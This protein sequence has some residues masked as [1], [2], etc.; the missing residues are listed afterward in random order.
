MID[1]REFV[2]GSLA[3][4]AAACTKTTAPEPVPVAK[5][6]PPVKQTILILGGTSFIGPHIVEAAL[7]RG[8]TITLFNRG[9]TRPGLFPNVEKL[10]GDR[11][12]QLAALKGRTWDAVVDT[13]GFVPRIVKQ[14]AELLAASVKQYIFISTISVY[15]EHAKIGADETAALEVAEDPAS[16]ELPKYYGA[17]KALSEQAAERA[18]PGR[19]MAIRPGLITG[20]LDAT[21]RFTHWVTRT[22]EGGE[23][24]APGD[25]TTPVQMIDSRDLAAW[26]VKSVE[27]RT[28][29]TYNA[30][31]P[32]HRLTMK[33][34]L[35]ACNAVG[36]NKATFTWVDA[37]FLDDHKVAP[38]SD[39]PVWIDA[40]D[41]WAGFGTMSNARAVKAGL[42]F[43]P[44]GETA[45]ATLDWLAD[46]DTAA[47]IADQPDKSAEGR[48]IDK[49]DKVRS[50][51]ISRD[52]EK[53]VLAAWHAKSAAR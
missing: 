51:G 28:V 22:A 38:W 43:R 19:V 34:M 8:H 23:V 24:L 11:D 36:G 41:E 7:A 32:A 48:T 15:K 50:S 33:E 40:K 4:L 30:L 44:V 52:R 14:S 53:A 35:D 46:P 3:A 45:K 25:G 21:G 18:L 47:W 12:G 17:L 2:I 37:A 10:H 6:E 9:K 29:G 49:R 39:M 42:T 31:G 1:R 26:I 16:E 27:A 13:S 5:P 20:P